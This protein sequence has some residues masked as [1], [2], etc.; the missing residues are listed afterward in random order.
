MA[1][2]EQLKAYIQ[3]LV[4]EEVA[5]VVPQLV[6][7]SLANAFGQIILEATDMLAEEVRPRGNTHKRVS[8]EESVDM[9]EYPSMNNR[10]YDSSRMSEIMGHTPPKKMANGRNMITVDTAMSE[11]GNPIPISPDQIPEAVLDAMN[12]DYR[13]LMKTL[14]KNR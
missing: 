14:N 6:R 2:N 7:E 4:K 3:K 1:T 9:E 5:K 11:A 13:P 12:K 10:T 8:L